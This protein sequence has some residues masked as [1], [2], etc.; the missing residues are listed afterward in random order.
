[1]GRERVIS[2]KKEVQ[3]SK[4]SVNSQNTE[5]ANPMDKSIR[6]QKDDSRKDEQIIQTETKIPSRVTMDSNSKTKKNYALKRYKVKKEEIIVIGEEIKY[7][8]LDSKIEREEA[9]KMFDRPEG[10][11]SIAEI[12]EIFMQAPFN[13]RNEESA[14]LMAR[15]LVEDQNDQIIYYDPELQNDCLMVKSIFEQVIPRYRIP[16][17]EE[18]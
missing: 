14:I 1:M 13:V 3:E 6:L 12:I 11:I 9:I 4:I 15:Y 16:S 10:Q 8:L 17:E 5:K 2:F 18:Y 7:K